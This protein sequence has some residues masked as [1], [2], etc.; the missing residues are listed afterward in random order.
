MN[1]TRSPLFS[2][3]HPTLE[4]RATHR[5]GQGVFATANLAKGKILIVMGG[6][7]LT[8]EDENALE[9]VVANKPIEL[10]DRFSIGPRT[11]DELARM[12]QHYINHSCDPNC[13]FNGQIFLVAMRDIQA[14][15]ELAYDYAMVM[16][17]SPDSVNYF[18]MT[19]EC[20]SPL[21]RGKVAEDDW[22]R[23]DLQAHYAGY[24]SWFLQ[25]R[26]DRQKRTASEKRT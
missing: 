11:P 1:H 19:C 26:I 6:C 12:P 23:P 20:G 7:I 24:F 4:V 25:G 16:H 15:E 22:Q 14:G 9:G 8:V 21:C 17:S 13:G 2:W 5:Y 10:S 18:S 3:M